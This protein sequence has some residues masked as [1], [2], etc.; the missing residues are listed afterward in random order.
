M[1]L[2]VELIQEVEHVLVISYIG[3]DV[4]EVIEEITILITAAITQSEGLVTVLV[5]L[6][7][8]VEGSTAGDC[9]VELVEGVGG[10]HGGGWLVMW[11]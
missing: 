3:L 2:L 10:V 11:E 6:A 8:Q 7:S 4:V 9:F 5:G 1:G